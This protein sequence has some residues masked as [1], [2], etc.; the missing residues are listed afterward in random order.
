MATFP[1]MGNRANFVVVA[2]GDWTLYYS[3]WGAIGLEFDLLPGPHAAT[4]YIRAQEV[5]PPDRRGWMD[6]DWCEAGAL[7]DLDRRV[8]L[9]FWLRTDPAERAAALA[10]ISRTWPGWQ[11]HWAYGGLADLAEYVGVDPKLVR[12]QHE[13]IVPHAREND[14]VGCLVTVTDEAGTRGYGLVGTDIEDIAR[15]GPG[16]VTQLPDG[17]LLTACTTTPN[18]GCHLDYTT[19]RAGAWTTETCVEPLERAWADWTGWRWEWWADDYE[20]HSARVAD[21]V[22][23]PA[24]DVS[25]ALRTLPD[26]LDRHRADD[27]VA[28]AHLVLAKLAEFGDIQAGPT[29]FQH[30]SVRMT[31][32]EYRAV[33]AVAHDLC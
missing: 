21:A 2:D 26:R 27:P 14:W 3:H 11:V 10:V 32:D 16:V 23:V 8:A 22:S 33:L 9:V 4:R 20:Q 5:V 7:L 28:N 6:N 17:A 29:V 15:L 30:R 12:Y 25:A 19:R 1:G 13:P 31:D 24:I 18:R